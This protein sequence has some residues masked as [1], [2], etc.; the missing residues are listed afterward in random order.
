MAI[1]LV[2]SRREPAPMRERLPVAAGIV[3]LAVLGHFLWNS[4]LLIV[5]ADAADRG[6]GLAAAARWVWR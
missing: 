2:V 4:P 3:A 5:R 6:S 1:G